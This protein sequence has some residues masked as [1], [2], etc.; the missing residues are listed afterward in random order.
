MQHYVKNYDSRQFGLFAIVSE[1]LNDWK[2]R[3]KCHFMDQYNFFCD[4]KNF[5]KLFFL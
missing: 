5:Y 3:M 4:E 1:P 2:D